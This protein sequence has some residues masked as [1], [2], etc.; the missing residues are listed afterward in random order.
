MSWVALL[1]PG[2]FT[3]TSDADA[4]EPERARR[5]R[6]L[7][8][9]GR[10]DQIRI[11]PL[12]PQERA[13]EVQ[14]VERLHRRRHRESRASEHQACET[15]GLEGPLDSGER[16]VKGADLVVVQR[17]REPKTVEPASCLDAEQLTR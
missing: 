13:G 9:V 3:P 2:G 17:S 11:P 5:T 14:R 8:V 6:L 7:R 15:N 1:L 4:L 12:P 10:E 16:P